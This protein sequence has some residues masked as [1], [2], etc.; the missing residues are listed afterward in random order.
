MALGVIES[1]Q[2]HP[3]YCWREKCSRPLSP[4][5]AKHNPMPWLDHHASREKVMS[6]FSLK[7]DD[8]MVTNKSFLTSMI[9]LRFILKSPRQGSE[10]TISRN[11]RSDESTPSR[12]CRC[13]PFSRIFLPSAH[14][15]QYQFTQ[16]QY[17]LGQF[18]I[19]LPRSSNLMKQG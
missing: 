8:I 10:S 11:Q 5:R 18:A 19:R 3:H 4:V 12:Q 2:S 15:L 7:L 13:H 9:T 1:H 16:S 6:N 14:L 17:R